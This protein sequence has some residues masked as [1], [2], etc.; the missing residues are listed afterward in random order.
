MAYGGSIYIDMGCIPRTDTS[1]A[2]EMNAEQ[3]EGRSEMV[4]HACKVHRIREQSLLTV[5][6]VKPLPSPFFACTLWPAACQGY[7]DP[8]ADSIL[9]VNQLCFYRSIRARMR[10]DSPPL[11]G[12]YTFTVY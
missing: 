7:L 8:S 12:T 4:N 6:K 2:L 9:P 10:Q 3:C 1:G 11:R 5:H